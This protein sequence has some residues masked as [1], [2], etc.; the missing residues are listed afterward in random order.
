MVVPSEDIE[1]LLYFVAVWFMFCWPVVAS[2]S[3]L[4]VGPLDVLGGS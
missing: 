2:A 3:S 1:A 4:F